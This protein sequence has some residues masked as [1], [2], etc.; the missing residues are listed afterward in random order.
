MVWA[1]PAVVLT[2][3]FGSCQEFSLKTMKAEVVAVTFRQETP[4]TAYQVTPAVFLS[5][6][7][8]GGQQDS[9]S[10]SVG[11]FWLLALLPGNCC[12]GQAQE[13]SDSCQAW[14]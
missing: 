9:S 2:H 5:P 14:S 1:S 8:S 7:V 12:A 3:L 11:G 10:S 4:G 13:G 6:A